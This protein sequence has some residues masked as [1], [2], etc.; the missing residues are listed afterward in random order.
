MKLRH[1]LFASA[2]LLGMPLW[3]PVGSAKAYTPG[4]TNTEIKIGQTMPYSGPASIYGTIG[5]AE[6]AYFRMI[7]D[8]GGINGRKVRIISLDDGY[9]PPKTVEQ[10]RKLVESEEVLLLFS[11]FGTA[12]NA[13]VQ[14]YLNQHGVP[15]LFP[16]SGATRWGDPEHFPWTIGFQ[17]TLQT[18]GRIIARYLLEHRPGAKIGV[19]YQNDD[20]GKDYVKGLKDGLGENAAAT[21]V[22]EV[23]YEG[24]EPTVDSQIIALKASGANV[25]VDVSTA[26]FT[27]QAIRKAYDIAW[28]PLHVVSSGATGRS[29]VLKPAGL[30]KAAGLISAAWAKDPTDPQWNDDAATKDWIAW[31][32]QYYP[33]GDRASAYNV[34]GYNWAMVLVEVLQRCGDDL[35]RANVMRQAANLDTSLPMLLPGI[36]VRTGPKQ[37]FPIRDMQLKR[38]NGDV[39]ESFSDVIRTE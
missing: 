24:T 27:A 17:P 34:A 39:W 14:R 38:F 20:F 36:K 12:T 35:T 29:E 6:V 7:N 13:A 1:W 8:R 37:F 33:E 11:M 22:G 15:Q 32:S 5:K 31:M 23:T 21:I 10:T 19:L 25:F 26:K 16:V 28:K 4:V 30:E 18:E 2:T 3:Q 9:T